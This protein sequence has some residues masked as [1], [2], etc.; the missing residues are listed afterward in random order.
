[1]E[2]ASKGNKENYTHLLLL[3]YL[4]LMMSGASAIFAYVSSTQDEALYTYGYLGF[5]AFTFTLFAIVR[6]YAIRKI[7]EQE[8]S[9]KGQS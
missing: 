5:C 9:D 1:M 4:I 2:G 7:K 6:R 8:K 3:G